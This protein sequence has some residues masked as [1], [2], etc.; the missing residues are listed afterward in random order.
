MKLGW[1]LLA[2]S[3]GALAALACTSAA[4]DAGGPDETDAGT[5]PSL[6]PPSTPGDAEAPPEAAAPFD[7]GPPKRLEVSCAG[8]P[9]Y[10]AVSGNGGRHY[11]GLLD[12]GTVRCWG[13]DSLT[14]L[15]SQDDD[16]GTTA[17]NDGALGSGDLASAIEGA[18]PAPVVG[19]SDVTQISVGPNFGTCAR[20]S[21]GSVYC[22]GRNDFGQ[23]GRPRSEARLPLP[24]RVEGL[25][26]VD[27][28][29]L[30][31]RTACAI[32]SS[33]KSLHCWGDTTINLAVDAGGTT[34]FAPQLVTAF[35]PPI[36]ALAIGT[37]TDKDTIITLL[38]DDVL[39]SIGEF[40]AGQSSLTTPATRPRKLPNVTSIGAFAYTSDGL[41]RRWRPQ[42]GVLYI[43]SSSEVVQVAIAGAN[44]QGGALL[45]PGR[46][47]RWGH[48]AGGALARSPFE[49]AAASHP[50]EMP[51]TKVVSFATTDKSTCAS[52]ED[53]KVMCWGSNVYGELGRGTMDSK[54]HPEPEEIR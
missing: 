41:L 13:R 26:P 28:V 30:G 51:V 54:A 36:K 6:P 39:A 45:A 3:V 23:L 10:R 32:A 11:C 14:P 47:F 8:A 31:Y 9:C 46:L 12:D 15:T 7:A 53:G 29:E 1:I 2:S 17:T 21:D 44:E 24:T 37:W 16:C 40:P 50:L 27:H 52:R 49:V 4:V 5:P 38:E 42:E 25:P 48:N 20:T 43:P 22:W 35:D 34:T 18:T 19:L 33:D